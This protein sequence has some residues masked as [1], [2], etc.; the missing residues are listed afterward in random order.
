MNE[1]GPLFIV[2]CGR[3]GTTLLKDLLNS[4]P[5]IKIPPESHFL[6]EFYKLYGD[7]TSDEEAIHLLER[8][9]NMYRFKR[10]DLDIEPE[11]VKHF[12]TYR[13][14]IN[15]VYSQ[16]AAKYEVPRWG[17]KTPHYV[18]YMD[19]ILELFPN[20][21]I[22]HMIRDGRDVALSIINREW[23]PNNVY[24]A[25]QFWK[26]TLDQGLPLAKNIPAD[27]YIEIRYEDLLRDPESTMQTICH[28]AGLTYSEKL[29][30]L[31]SLK[32]DSYIKETKNFFGKNTSYRPSS[33]KIVASPDKM[34]GAN[35][36]KRQARV[37]NA[38]A[39]DLLH[40]LG[41]LPEKPEP[42]T[43]SPIAKWWYTAHSFAL[44]VFKEFTSP[45]IFKRLTNWD[46]LPFVNN[47]TKVL[48]KK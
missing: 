28:F 37:F 29:L 41:Y 48:N 25:A 3:S 40:E 27:Q 47:P 2:G 44:K 38:V 4:S 17:E 46:T 5:E 36:N 35:L 12:R 19:D 42:V 13:E 21:R 18:K 8:L 15:Y 22:V 34:S 39:G 23:G 7:P 31:N 33:T 6:L 10:Y 30:E 16:F 20:A 43:L 32:E 9:Q 24:K 1:N 45:D 26:K 14:F 11:D